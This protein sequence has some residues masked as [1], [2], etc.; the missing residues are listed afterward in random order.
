MKRLTWAWLAA[1]VHSFISDDLVYGMIRDDLDVQYVV[2]LRLV[3][4]RQD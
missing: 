2:V 1:L 4:G 3:R